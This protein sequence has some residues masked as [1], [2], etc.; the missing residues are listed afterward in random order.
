VA[1]ST[2]KYFTPR[3]ISLEGVGITPDVE[4]TLDEETAAKVYYGQ[5]DPMEDPQILAALE[6]WK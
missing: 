1:L 4:I 6:L 3:G 5:L 2:G